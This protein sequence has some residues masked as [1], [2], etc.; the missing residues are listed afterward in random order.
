MELA[1]ARYRDT[2]SR[3]IT[4]AVLTGRIRLCGKSRSGFSARFSQTVGMGPMAY[5]QHWRM[6][7][8]KDELRTG[9]RSVTEIAYLVG[10]QSSSA[11]INAF[12][13]ENGCSPT[14]WTRR[15]TDLDQDD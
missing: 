5:M 12:T 7:V 11:F 2:Q 1:D 6:A 3:L 13:R 15:T 10:F 4:A 14:R 9:R 8:A